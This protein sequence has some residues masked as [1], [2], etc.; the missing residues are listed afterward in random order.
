MMVVGGG[1]KL[2]I[3]TSLH[4]SIPSSISLVPPVGMTL[5]V[6]DKQNGSNDTWY[7]VLKVKARYVFSSFLVRDLILNV[8][9]AW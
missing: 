2:G 8:R 1:G 3:F 9:V 7:A 4:I 5:G 6:M